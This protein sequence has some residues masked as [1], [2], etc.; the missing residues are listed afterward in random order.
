MW[1]PYQAVSCR[2]SGG[3]ETDFSFEKLVLKNVIL[4]SVPF[5]PDALSIFR[6]T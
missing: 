3:S 6:Q 5:I 1:G 2:L 4:R